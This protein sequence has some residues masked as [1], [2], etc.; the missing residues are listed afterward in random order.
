MAGWIEQA[1]FLSELDREARRQLEVLRPQ[2]VPDR[3]TLFRP[4]D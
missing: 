2:H 1:S 4:G 3:T